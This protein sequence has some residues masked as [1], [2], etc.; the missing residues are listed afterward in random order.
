MISNPDCCW[1]NYYVYRDSDG[2]EQCKIIPW[3]V[4]LSFGH[5]EVYDNN[6][7]HTNGLFQSGNDV[8]SHL[9]GLPGFR[10]MHLRRLRTL[11][12]EVVQLPGTPKDQL[13]YEARIDE[14]IAQI[15]DDAALDQATW[16]F[17]QLVYPQTPAEAA[18]DLKNV[19]FP[20]RRNFLDGRGDYLHHRLGI[21]LSIS[22]LLT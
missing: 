2:T 5:N 21:R 17:H 1:K 13:K 9:H 7:I 6:L 11:L 10:E 19:F 22:T 4:E 8:I 20:R 14:I 12:D 15:G 3:N 18:E 16:G